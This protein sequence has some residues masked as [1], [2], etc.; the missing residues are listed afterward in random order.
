MSKDRLRKLLGAATIAAV[1]LSIV[2]LVIPVNFTFASNP[3][4]TSITPSLV[5]NSGTQAISSVGGTGFTTETGLVG[6][7]SLEG[8]ANDSSGS[9]NNATGYNVSYGTAYGRFGQGASFNGSSSYI[10]TPNLSAINSNTQPYSVAVWFKAAAA[11]VIV[12]ETGSTSINSGWHQSFME[13]LSSGSVAVRVYNLSTLTAGTATFNTWNQVVL[14]YDG[15][16]VRSY[17]NGVAGGTTT[18]TR[19][20]PGAS[21]YG[22]YLNLGAT[23]STNLGSGA[24]F[25]GSIDE[26]RVYSR[27]LSST[28]VT[29]LYNQN[30]FIQVQLTKTGQSTVTCNSFFPTNS[31]T[32]S[33]GW[34]PVNSIATGQWNVVVTNPDNGTA[35]LANGLTVTAPT[36]SY[37]RPITVNNQYP[38]NGVV[39]NWHLD[40][41]SQDSSGN[42]NNG[43]DTSVT[44][45]TQYGKFGQGASFNGSNSLISLPNGTGASGTTWTGS[46]WINFTTTVSPNIAVVFAEKSSNTG[47]FFSNIN[48]TAIGAIECAIYNNSSNYYVISASSGYNDGKWHNVV[49]VENGATLY[50]YIDG[51]LSNSGPSSGFSVVYNYGYLGANGGGT[52][53]N[54][55]LDEVRVYNRALSPA[56]VQDLYSY[57]TSRVALSNYPVL[58]QNP[59]YNETGLVGSWHMEGNSQDSSGNGNNG[60]DTNVTYGTSYGE[61][62]KGAHFVNASQS[63][64]VVPYN[65]A[66]NGNSWSVSFW[67]KIDSD[68]PSGTA[69]A[70][71]NSQGGDG[72]NIFLVYAN[73]TGLTGFGRNSS[74]TQYS[75][76]Y[77][78]SLTSWTYIAMVWDTSGGYLRLYING[79]AVSPTA[80]SGNA[81]TGTSPLWIG[82]G[83]PNPSDTYTINGEMDEVRLYNRVLTST[84][85]ANLYAAHA[86][87][88]YQ[89][90]RF[91]DSD[92]I[93]QLNFYRPMDGKFWVAVPSIPVGVKTIYIEYGSSS[94][95][96]ASNPA[97]AP[98]G[99][100][101]DWNMDEP[102][103][104]TSY[105][106]S[107]NNYN[108]T[109]TNTAVVSGKFG[110]AQ[111]FNGSSSYIGIP[112]LQTGL[113]SMTMSVWINI[114][115]LSNGGNFIDF[116]SNGVTATI[117]SIG[118]GV[119]SSGV[120]YISKETAP[121][122]TWEQLNSTSTYPINTW[123]HVVG[124][125]TNISGTG[126]LNLYV[127]GSLAAT[128][129]SFAD[130]AN[131]V[132]EQYS[133][134][135]GTNHAAMQESAYLD[136]IRVYNTALSATQVQQLY[137]NPTLTLVLSE[138]PNPTSPTVSTVTPLVGSP[139]GGTPVTIGGS[140]FNQLYQVPITVTN[141]GP[142]VNDYQI[143][144]QNPIY[145][146]TGLVGSW[147]LEGNSL[148]SSGNNNNGTD[149]NVTYGAAYGEYGQGASFNGSSS[150]ISLGA[151]S[152]L[153]SLSGSSIVQF[154]A[155]IYLKAVPT[156]GNRFYIIR[157]GQESTSMWG[158]SVLSPDGTNAYLTFRSA[159]PG[160]NGR[161]QMSNTAI[162]LN[163]WH[164]VTAEAQGGTA[165]AT[166][167][168][169]GV[170]QSLTLADGSNANYVF[171]S[172]SAN[173]YIG[174]D[175][176]GNY[177]N[178]YIDEVRVYNRVLSSTEITN[179]Y[180]AHAAPN[181]QNVRFY[182]SDGVT[183]LPYWMQQDGMFWVR[184]PYIPNGNKTIYI[185][186]GNA[187]MT[188]GSNGDDTFLMFDD[189]KNNVIDTSKWVTQ[190]AAG[191]ITE[192]N[193]YL[194][195]YRNTGGTN[196]IQTVTGLSLSN[197]TVDFAASAASVASNIQLGIM[198]ANQADGNG[199]YP[200][201]TSGNVFNIYKRTPGTWTLL[202]GS[203]GSYNP[204]VFANYKM[205]KNGSNFSFYNSSGQIGS[206]QTISV[207]NI[208]YLL[209]PR[210]WNESPG[211]GGTLDINNFRVRRYAAV[212]PTTSVGSEMAV[213]PTVT[214]GGTAATGVTYNSSSSLGATTPA[215]ALGVVD[216]LVTNPDGGVG[217]LTGGF[218]Y[219]VASN[220]FFLLFD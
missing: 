117:P 73:T 80:I 79:A 107:G 39:G 15:T 93:T 25:S 114:T 29:S 123:H 58:I 43:T 190:I 13:I 202:Q 67:L 149:S 69:I 76:S 100:V 187:N 189:F 49:C 127:D 62:G 103:V 37:R 89:D 168:I 5:V 1:L 125:Y 116:R 83:S 40:G 198:D 122:Y 4:V 61:F 204:G 193:G 108:G 6:L 87:L 85:I 156:S 3:T 34:C 136:E 19:S 126:Y 160:Q 8:N 141:N 96:D 167:Y 147:H 119:L 94:A 139:T 53:L 201:F 191:S 146:E 217:T 32:L 72:S 135:G 71:W 50:L 197:Y 161:E 47:A 84:E 124:T 105:D 153:T 101:A 194:S 186:Y 142:A 180:Q 7:W 158:M 154:A 45:G 214:F 143:L 109:D 211:E 174:R 183:P 132:P 200:F 104:G 78:G 81:L 155:W 130:A 56:E 22:E 170:Q 52:S 169:D 82:D 172:S 134:I 18:G 10:Q 128:Q 38:E 212:E 118:L 14:T 213:G 159:A 188:S 2:S 33:N 181:Y 95:T 129:M 220:G 157:Q 151:P 66:M 131:S 140:G 179:L 175:S 205:I 28:E 210:V 60:T 171:S 99:L 192:A 185:R 182:D 177:W 42:G 208:T 115:N 178:G 102:L 75:V 59:I 209:A 162:T 23:D 36:F 145:N 31:T 216:V 12:D 55:S 195:I 68:V 206:T 106:S 41:N 27:V 166:L 207:G 203:V 65:S 138:E 113:S 30:G 150:G 91:V 21:S 92:G 120:F 173:I 112:N 70:R 46:Y 16:T 133:T 57:N 110:N 74:N 64:I 164:F 88:N 44:Y 165:T 196:T 219:G 163:T 111:S 20:S 98:M 48:R 24:W 86:A 35:T 121:N 51:I 11:G 148:D 9:G 77:S 97:Y 176:S 144:V 63:K 215:H 54:G 26:F 137:N 218:T 184:V 152:S 90:V 17:L 199:F